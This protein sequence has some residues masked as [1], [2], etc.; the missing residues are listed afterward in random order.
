MLDYQKRRFMLTRS[1]IRIHRG[2][3]LIELITVVALIAVLAALG[4][5]SYS[6]WVQNTRIR[7]TAEA[8]QN[9]LQIA[10][11]EAVKRNARVQF[12]LE[13]N[14][15][16][17]VG[18]VD[19]VADLDGDGLDDCPEII[20]GRSAGEGSSPNIKI[21][22]IPDG[23]TTVVFNSMGAINPIPAP[24]TQVEIDIDET[25]MSGEDSRELRVLLGV[26]GST[27]MCDPNASDNDPRVC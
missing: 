6:N 9:G 24:F 26:G 27:R 7:T 25:V 18:C 11:A 5:P 17:T 2:L 1:T 15:E 4:M 13:N 12:V 16:W 3:S 20:Q 14:A 21:T 10:R 23:N 22:V 19:E 8:I